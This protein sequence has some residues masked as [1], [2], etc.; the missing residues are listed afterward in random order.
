MHASGANRVTRWVVATTA[1]LL[2][3]TPTVADPRDTALAAAIPAA[4]QALMV[5]ADLS[6]GL[7]EMAPMPDALLIGAEAVEA[8]RSRQRESK[9]DI[10]A[11]PGDADMTFLDELVT[12][13]FDG[14]N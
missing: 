4:T 11:R 3:V 14:F 12:Q 1:L 5:A 8:D 2:V 10:A 13:Y 7:G 6:E 9:V